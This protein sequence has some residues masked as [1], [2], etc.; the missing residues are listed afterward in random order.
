MSE[1]T[2]LLRES[3]ETRQLFTAACERLNARLDEFLATV[4]E[5]ADEIEGGAA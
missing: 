4:R 1:Y 2:A 3:E 5:A